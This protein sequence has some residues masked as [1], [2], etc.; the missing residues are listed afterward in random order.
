MREGKEGEGLGGEEG[1]EGTEGGGEREK[2]GM[3][4]VSIWGYW[5]FVVDADGTITNDFLLDGP[6]TQIKLTR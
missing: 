2:K 1:G 4:C 6:F 5:R 3:V